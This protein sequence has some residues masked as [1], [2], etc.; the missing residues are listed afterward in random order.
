MNNNCN[1]APLLQNGKFTVQGQKSILKQK[2]C[3]TFFK[4]IFSKQWTWDGQ[5]KNANFLWNAIKASS[6]TSTRVYSSMSWEWD[7]Q[8]KKELLDLMNLPGS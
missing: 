6:A 3:R 5:N 2:L 7:C 8:K 1:T 4:T